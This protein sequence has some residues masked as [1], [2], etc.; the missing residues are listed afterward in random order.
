M[1]LELTHINR[2]YNEGSLEQRRN[3]LDDISFSIDT[4]ETCAIVGPSGSGKSTMLN[5]MGT[6]DAPNSGVVRFR[7]VEISSLK[8]PELAAIRNR[9]IGFVFQMHYLLPQ[10]SLLENVLLPVIPGKSKVNYQ[11]IEEWA[12]QL[13]KL[14]DLHDK[15][16]RLPGQLSVG[17]C[18]RTAVVRALINKPELL[19]AD[20][21]TGSL[22][23]NSASQMGELLKEINAKYSVTMILVTHSMELAKNMERIY[24][25]DNGKL[26][27][28]V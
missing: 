10:L 3:V 26:L 13:L 1:L 25:L 24:R 22:D 4:G 18:Q 2:Y 28:S 19:L 7:G 23:H 20:E 16:K 14:V 5:I 15:T 6:L 11:A 17:E 21:P 12:I 27:N 9:H 8:E